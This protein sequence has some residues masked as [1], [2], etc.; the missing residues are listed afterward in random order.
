MAGGAWLFA[1]QVAAL[2]VFQTDVLVVSAL[3]GPLAA[4]SFQATARL[5]AQV[6]MV[7]GILLA[8]LW[9]ALATAWAQGDLPWI[10]AIHRRAAG[11]TLGILVPLCLA[12]ALLA[13]P[14]V[15]L[16]T[17][18]ARLAPG[19]WLAAGL[20]L[21]CATA[22]W[23]G[24]HAYCLNATGATRGPAILALVQAALNLPATVVA[25]HLWGGAGVAWASALCALCTS[26][27]VLTWQYRRRM[28]ER[29]R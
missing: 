24:L 2:V 6:V 16:W 1:S 28:T 26:V 8:A 12:G 21:G 15:R 9:P 29:Q 4:G 18:D 7:Q 17:G 10:R 19:P 5:F 13:G 23:A 27:P 14:V 11:L 25:A 20:A 3:L 22:L